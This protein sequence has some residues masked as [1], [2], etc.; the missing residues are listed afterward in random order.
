MHAHVM[1]SPP[2][3]KPR[4]VKP[5][6]P[7]PRGIGPQPHYDSSIHRGDNSFKPLHL[8]ALVL[9]GSH[10]GGCV[11]G[12]GGAELFTDHDPPSLHRFAKLAGSRYD[13]STGTILAGFWSE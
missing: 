9:R 6:P 10:E 7:A 13:P 12:G 3:R 5:T 2:R 1:F 8:G 11:S 4:Y